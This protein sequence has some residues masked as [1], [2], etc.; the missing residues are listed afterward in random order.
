MRGLRMLR[1]MSVGKNAVKAGSDL[2]GNFGCHLTWHW[3]VFGKL[4]QHREG[5]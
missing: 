5:T 3:N 4:Q 2:F 1:A